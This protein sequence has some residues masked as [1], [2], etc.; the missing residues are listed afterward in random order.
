MTPQRRVQLLCVN[1]NPATF[2]HYSR[3]RLHLAWILSSASSF[4]KYRVWDAGRRPGPQP[5]PAPDRPT[6]VR[7]SWL[8]RTR[9]RRRPLH[10][11]STRGASSWLADDFV[12]CADRL[13]LLDR[14]TVIRRRGNR[15]P[16]RSAACPPRRKAASVDPACADACRRN[17][18]CS[19]TSSTRRSSAACPG[20]F[21]GEDIAHPA[22]P[23]AVTAERR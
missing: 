20:Y 1:H 9:R 2:P 3:P 17:C 6:C 16:G 8:S 13:P 4:G 19:P 18:P 11:H 5:E 22:E 12:R 21:A 7:G 15:R 14:A 23:A 10:H